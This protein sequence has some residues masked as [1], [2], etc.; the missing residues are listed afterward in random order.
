M[1][2]NMKAAVGVNV[3]EKINPHDQCCIPHGS[4]IG[5]P[6][7][8]LRCKSDIFIIPTVK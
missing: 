6:E 5:V 3:A 8:V 2:T 1:M 4:G 7:Q